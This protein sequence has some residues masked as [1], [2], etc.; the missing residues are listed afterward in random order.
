VELVFVFRHVPHETLGTV[1]TA[2]Q[3]AGLATRY[4]DLFDS[5]EVPEGRQLERAAGLVVLGGPMNVDETDK[6]PFLAAEVQRIREAV[7]AEVPVLGICL[8]AQLLAKALGA[9]ITAN[10]VKE[11]G[12][13]PLQ[14]TP[15]AA[16]DPLLAGC[17]D[18]ATVFQWHGDTFALPAGTVHLARSKACE[19][20]AFRC[21]I[22]AYALQFHIEVTAEM[23]D[24]WLSDPNNRRELAALDYIDPQAIRRQTPEKL[25]AMAALGARVFARFASMCKDRAERLRS[26]G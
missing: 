13:Y 22:S 21:G 19:N 9:R 8:G 7:D 24:D 4:V 20:Q 17:G 26:V 1:A 10:R 2:L 25:P 12:W 15:Q 14:F 11:I 5:P 3:S 18:A 6:Y 16:A 23:I